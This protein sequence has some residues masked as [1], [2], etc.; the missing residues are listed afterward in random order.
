MFTRTMKGVAI[1][2]AV[3]ALFASG[4][5]FAGEKTTHQK[6]AAGVVQCAGINECKGHGACAGADN[7][8]KAQNACK[9]QGW[10]ETKSAQECMEK[11]GKVLV[12]KK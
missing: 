7:A 12:A 11:G 8:C 5:A 4:T 2:G 1:A 10:V 6:T 9:G 3:G